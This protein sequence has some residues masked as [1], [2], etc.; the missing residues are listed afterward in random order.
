MD[1]SVELK[2]LIVPTFMSDYFRLADLVLVLI[3][4]S[5]E[6]ERAFSALKWLKED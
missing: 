2:P 5:V 3:G 4:G 1:L 6:D